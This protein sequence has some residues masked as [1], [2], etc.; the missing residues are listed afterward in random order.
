M[1][2]LG[3]ASI[4]AYLEEQGKKADILDSYVAMLKHSPDSWLR[5]AANLGS[6]L[7]FARS[8]ESRMLK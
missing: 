3:L 7:N 1:P 4:A 5:F 8:S 6:F 2:P